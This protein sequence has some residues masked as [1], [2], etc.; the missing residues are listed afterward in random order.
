MS[1]PAFLLNGRFLTR[2]MSGVDRAALH[3]VRAVLRVRAEGLCE[4]FVLDVAVPAGAPEDAQIR[5]R[6]SLPDDSTIH[7]SRHSGY[8]WEQTEL[9]GTRPEMTLLSLCSSGPVSRENQ[10]VLIHDAQVFD[11]PES[12]SLA[13]RKTCHAM[14][15]SLARRSRHVATVSRYSRGRLHANRIGASRAVEIVRNGMDHLRTV[16]GDPDVLKAHGLGKGEYFFAIDSREDHKNIAMLLQAHAARR[17]GRMPLVLAGSGAGRA[18]LR[19][20]RLPTPEIVRLG[21]V[22]DQ[23]LV[24]LYR[25]ARAFLLPSRSE[26]FGLTAGEAMT[27]ACP[28]IAASCGALPEIYAGAAMFVDPLDVAGWAAAMDEL[29]V[30]DLARETWANKG[31]DRSAM[32]PWHAGAESLLNILGVHTFDAKFPPLGARKTRRSEQ[33]TP[34]LRP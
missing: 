17:I 4:A 3:L 30:D 20:A 28:V 34:T 32:F 25:H 16:P 11:E 10:L 26:G 23:A 14:L 15:P 5:E 31:R 1:R 24:T 13:F 22:S 18:G 12:Y 33:S 19:G 29:E 8:V 2:P 21:R 6:L 7:R 9:A 27:L